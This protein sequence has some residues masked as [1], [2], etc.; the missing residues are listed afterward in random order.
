[1]CFW[2]QVPTTKIANKIN[3]YFFIYFFNF[4]I[5]YTFI[6]IFIN[7]LDKNIANSVNNKNVTFVKIT[8]VDSCHNNALICHSNVIFIGY[9]PVG[10]ATK[11]T[12]PNL[13]RT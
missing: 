1:M 7:Q 10:Y 5:L 9:A 11:T 3:R 13:I 8:F 2:Q 12:P 4:F 6:I